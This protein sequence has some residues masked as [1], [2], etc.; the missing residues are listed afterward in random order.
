MLGGVIRGI[1]EKKE[2]DPEMLTKKSESGI[3]YASGLIAGEGLIGII[4]AIFVTGGITFSLK[5]HLFGPFGGLI[6]FLLLAASLVY[7]AFYKVKK[8]KA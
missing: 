1:L 4:I 2:K 7:Y 8:E 5:D 6:F 3:L